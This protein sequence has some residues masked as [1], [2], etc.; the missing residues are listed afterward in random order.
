MTDRLRAQAKEPEK[1]DRMVKLM[2]ATEN[3]EDLQTATLLYVLDMSYDR[4]DICLA[5][6]AVKQSKGW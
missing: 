5:E 4:G 3:R 1:F 6:K 2:G